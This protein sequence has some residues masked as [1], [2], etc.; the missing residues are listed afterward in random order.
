MQQSQALLEPR[1][2]FVISDMSWRVVPSKDHSLA[3]V[4]T[5]VSLE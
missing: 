3:C 4:E 5:L 1:C 2:G